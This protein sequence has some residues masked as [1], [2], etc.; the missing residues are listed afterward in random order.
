MPDGG[1]RSQAHRG[2]AGK[3]RMTTDWLETAPRASLSRAQV[4]AAGLP[5]WS[6]ATGSS[7]SE[8][9]FDGRRFRRLTVKGDLRPVSA[10]AAPESGWRH[11]RGCDC[12]LCGST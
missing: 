6:A 11:R 7:G 9:A 2:K 3:R 8:F 4:A 10:S 12:A 1:F 5:A